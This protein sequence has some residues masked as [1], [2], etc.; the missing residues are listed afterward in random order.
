VVA[1]E[2]VPPSRQGVNVPA[3]LETICLKCLHKEPGR[4][5]ASAEELADDLGRFQ[6]DEPIRALPVGA[7]E[8]SVKWAKHRPALAA[9]LGVTLLAL[10]LLTVL[11][12]N[13]VVKEQAA[14]QEA[15]KAKKARDFLVSIFRIS[16]EDTHE[17]NITARQ[18]LA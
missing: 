2:P 8:R 13:L 3:D 14:R 4:R 11:S 15:D 1:D 9:L 10:V 17:G 7:V 18:I 5:Y 12:G 16:E 6:V